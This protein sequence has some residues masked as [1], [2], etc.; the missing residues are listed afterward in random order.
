[1]NKDNLDVVLHEV[2]D[3][4]DIDDVCQFLALRYLTSEMRGINIDKSLSAFSSL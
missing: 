3:E 2:V 4:D 1:M